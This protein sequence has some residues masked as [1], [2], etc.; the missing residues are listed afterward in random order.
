MSAILLP[1]RMTGGGGTGDGGLGIS[2]GGKL[3]TSGSVGLSE[4][5]RTNSDVNQGQGLSIQ[6]VKGDVSGLNPNRQRGFGNSVSFPRIETPRLADMKAKQGA[7]VARFLTFAQRKSSLVIE[8]YNAS[9]YKQKPNWD[10]IANFVYSDLCTTSALRKEII[11]VQFHPVKMLIFLKFSEDQWRDKV[12]EKLQS[13]DGVI[14]RE[15]GVKVRGYSLDAEVKFFRLLGVSPETDAE[16]IKR[17]FKE[18]EIGDVIE[19]KKGLLDEK[20]L[21]GVSNGT[22][23]LR[24]KI[25]DPEKYI[26]SYIHRRD[27]GE[28]WSLNFEGRVF[29]CWKCG[30]GD[31]IGDKCRDQTKTFE[32]V[33]NNSDEDFVK[34]TW[35]TVVRSGKAT[36]EAQEKIT[37]EMETKLKEANKR[38]RSRSIAADRNEALSTAVINVEADAARLAKPDVRVNPNEL[39]QPNQVSDSDLLKSVVNMDR[40]SGVSDLVKETVSHTIHDSLSKSKE[41]LQISGDGDGDGKD[42]SYVFG[43]GATKLAKE[44]QNKCKDDKASSDSSVDTSTPL[45]KRSRGRRRSRHSGRSSM[46]SPSPIR[47][48]D[49]VNKK[50]RYDDVGSEEQGESAMKEDLLAPK[51]EGEGEEEILTAETG[52]QEIQ[53]QNTS[54]DWGSSFEEERS[55]VKDFQVNTQRDLG[56][57]ESPQA[58]QGT[59]SLQEGT[60]GSSKD[61]D[62]IKDGVL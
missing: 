41:E 59:D 53:N 38:R 16:E 42:M 3:G 50:I 7:V 6:A 33:F 35:A 20:R 12:V 29:C 30:S 10:K 24:V 43:S 62:S 40:Q 13:A 5:V 31:H 27:E 18:A 47:P 56:K 15:Y 36:N 52:A 14:W 25:S 49:T 28:I 34:P 58:I 61:R 60:A 54:G 48:P 32:E 8:L 55:Q 19:I 11:D 23:S 9:F 4:N 2:S 51:G 21:P 44:L 57:L 39:S 37:K 17:S 46:S 45:R 26:P 22:W 1:A